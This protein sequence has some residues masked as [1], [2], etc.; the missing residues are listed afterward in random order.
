M[1]ASKLNTQPSKQ[2]IDFFSELSKIL[3]DSISP[4][5]NPLNSTEKL[6]VIIST[7]S[8]PSLPSTENDI[9]LIS[10]EKLHPN[11]ITLKCNH[12]FNYM[13]IYKEVLYQ[14]NKSNTIYEV[15]KLQPYQI[16]CPYCRNITDKLLPFIP[17]PCV[18]LAKN[19]HAAE[20]DCITAVKCSHI[21]K[22]R[23]LNKCDIQCDKNAMY[24]EMENL[25]FCPS[26]YKKYISK[27]VSGG[28]SGG[29]SGNSDTTNKPMSTKPLCPAILKSGANSGKPCNSIISID[30]SQFCKRHSR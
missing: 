8:L 14:K 5:P 7:S 19:I 18:K 30:G 21:I 20:P 11:H 25:L 29:V 3:N 2:S 6:N 24:C 10:K 27:H 15:T 26:H 17:Y 12:K 9:C 23:T 28:V 22:S 1:L 4:S 16:K 13:H